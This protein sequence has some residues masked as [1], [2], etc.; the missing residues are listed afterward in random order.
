MR[1]EQP[2]DPG[3]ILWIL[4]LPVFVGIVLWILG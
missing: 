2:E 4:A 1:S 3:A